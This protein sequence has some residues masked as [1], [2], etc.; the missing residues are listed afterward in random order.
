MKILKY[1]LLLLFAGALFVSCEDQIHTSSMPIPNDITFNAEEKGLDIEVPKLDFVQLD[2]P[3]TARAYHYGSITMNAKKKADGTHVGFALSNKNYRSYPWCNA[4]TSKN[5]NPQPSAETLQKATD[6]LLFSCFTNS[7][8]NK[9][10]NFAVVRVEGE[11]AYFTIDKPRV[12]E[13]ILV[14]NCTFNYLALYYGS[15]YSAQMNYTDYSY[16]EKRTNGALAVTRN[17]NIPD[18]ST[19]K[20]GVWF[21]PDSY[22]FSQGTP[23]TRMYGNPYKKDYYFKVVATGYNGGT[24]TGTVDIWL[25]LRK[26]VATEEPYNLW[27]SRIELEWLPWDMSSLGEVD[28]VVFTMDCSEKNADGSLHIAPYFCID[29][30]RLK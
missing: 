27:D 10:K 12:I 28:K 14:T 4:K 21:L 5:M 3:F 20:Y 9:L 15:V 26:G 23:W 25:A 19:A 1:T 30:I 29:G 11:E 16:L 6:T 13:H 24:K 7:Y 22:N 17:P 2:A 18:P 8:A